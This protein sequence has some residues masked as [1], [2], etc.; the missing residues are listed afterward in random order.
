MNCLHSW[1]RRMG[2]RDIEVVKQLAAAG[3]IKVID[4]GIVQKCTVCLE[5]KLA[6]DSFPKKSAS[7][8]K[9]ILD[10]VHADVC[11]P[12]EPAT[13]SGNRYV[14]TLIDDFS[15]FCILFHLKLKSDVASCTLGRGYGNGSLYPKSDS[16]FCHRWRR[17]VHQVE[18]PELDKLR[19]FGSRVFAHIP[20]QKRRKLEPKSVEYVFVGYATGTKGYRLLNTADASITISR[21][22]SFVDDY[23]VAPTIELSDTPNVNRRPVEDVET[24]DDASE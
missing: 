10:L 5:G 12:L 22:V 8:T 18:E 14:L 3:R 13:P 4:C 1:H 20:A 17:A 21:D 15:R 16:E 19:R 2:H 24:K 6:R 11:G 7:K 9:R 23:D